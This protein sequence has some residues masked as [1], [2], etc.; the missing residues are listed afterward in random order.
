LLWFL[1]DIIAVVIIF[2]VGLGTA[3]IARGNEAVAVGGFIL[4]WIL[5]V[6]WL[7]FATVQT[8]VQI[9]HIVQMAGA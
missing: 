7:I 9:I 5:A 1:K 4:G 8:I 3:A 2:V 6:G